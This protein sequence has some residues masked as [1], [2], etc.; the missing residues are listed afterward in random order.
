MA[1]ADIADPQGRFCVLAADHRESLKKFLRPEA[2][3]SVADE[4]LT[5]LKADLARVV[6]PY[7]TGMM[8][9]PEYSIPQVSAAG[10]LAP[11]V[12]FIAA[13][14][15]Q[16]YNLDPLTAVT[17]LLPGWSAAQAAESGA[18]AAKLLVPY[19]PERPTAAAQVE[20]VGQVI[21][22]CHEAGLP[23]VLEPVAFVYE[24]PDE[25]TDVIVETV[26]TMQRLGPDLLKVPFPGFADDRSDWDTACARVGAELTIPWAILSGGGTFDDFAT[27]LTAATGAGCHGFMVGRA[28]WAEAA[29]CDGEERQQ[30]LET[31]VV[32]RMRQLSGIV[33]GHPTPD[34]A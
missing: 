5:R 31:V 11:G 28:L 25:Q 6:S 18:A 24:H 30:V 14:E 7:A 29:H 10:L 9:D 8:L 15:S 34:P 21:A 2:P 16:D 32:P 27:Q 19:H 13:L 22:Q 26:R 20:A 4:D 1:L 23:L 33:T 17:T 12:G 3:G